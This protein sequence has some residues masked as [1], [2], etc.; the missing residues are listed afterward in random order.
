M[1]EE[2]STQATKFKEAA[3]KLGCDE[4]EERF[5]EALKKVARHKPV[6]PEE[7]RKPK[8]PASEGR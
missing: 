8:E 7:K 1:P 3:R 5:N 6:K 2:S 4:S